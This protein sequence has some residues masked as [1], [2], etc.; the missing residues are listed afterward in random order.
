[1]WFKTPKQRLREAALRIIQ[2]LADGTIVPDPPLVTD[3]QPETEK[4]GDV[5]QIETPS[6]IPSKVGGAVPHVSRK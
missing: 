6:A 5:A 2:G 1:M 4:S 3:A